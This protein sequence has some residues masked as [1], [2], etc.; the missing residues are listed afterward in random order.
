MWC[1][2]LGEISWKFRVKN[3]VLHSQGTF[4]VHWTKKK[5]DWIGHISRRNCL[6]KH[7]IER[8]SKGSV[9]EKE[10]ISCYWMRLRKEVRHRTLREEALDRTVWGIRL[11]RGRGHFLRWTPKWSNEWIY[12][13]MCEWMNIWMNTWVNVWINEYMNEWMCEWMNTWIN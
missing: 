3:E 1:W 6:L 7:A 11:G 10:D 12:E 2:R 13:W 9:N 4:Y 5:A 8:K